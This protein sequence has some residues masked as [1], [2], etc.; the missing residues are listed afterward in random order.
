[1]LPLLS[2]IQKVSRRGF[3]LR[4]PVEVEVSRRGFWPS[5]M[6][7]LPLLSTIQKVSRRGFPLRF[8]VEVEVSR[9]G[10]WPSGMPML[11]LLSTIQKRIG[12]VLADSTARTPWTGRAAPW[13][14]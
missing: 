8:P 1:M 11:P 4:F 7:M 13:M 5:G 14:P 10:F 2:T 9:R 3:P 6:P 12:K